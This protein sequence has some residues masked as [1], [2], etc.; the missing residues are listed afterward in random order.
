[1]K[2]VF[3]RIMSLLQSRSI[4]SGVLLI[5][6][7]FLLSGCMM[8]PPSS[9][10][11]SIET[12]LVSLDEETQEI[13]LTPSF[14]PISTTKVGTSVQVD[15]TI[16][17]ASSVTPR[18]IESEK[19]QSISV[20]YDATFSMMGFADVLGVTSY[21]N[22]LSVV[23]SSLGISFPEIAQSQIK[24]Y[25]MNKPS[26]D[27]FDGIV[28]QTSMGNP[29]FYLNGDF[30]EHPERVKLKD[31][32]TVQR[33]LRMNEPVRGFQ[34]G[35][36]A[37]VTKESREPVSEALGLLKPD[38]FLVVVTD[39]EELQNVGNTL[40]SHIQENVYA[41]GM[42][43]SITAINSSF[44]GFVPLISQGV[45]TWF[46]WG[47]QPT[48]SC[49]RM[50]DYQDYKIG[51]TIDPTKRESQK[52]PFYIICA[53]NSDSVNGYC[54]AVLSQLD[55]MKIPSETSIF[56]FNIEPTIYQKPGDEGAMVYSKLEDKTNT[57]PKV[58]SGI[59]I[60]PLDDDKAVKNI[61][62]EKGKSDNGRLIEFEIEIEP[63]DG[64]PRKEVLSNDSKSS[65]DNAFFVNVFLQDLEA[66]G[67]YGE[68][69]PVKQEEI[70]TSCSTENEVGVRDRVNLH[71]RY[72][73]PEKG[74]RLEKGMRYLVTTEV[75]MRAP[76]P[77]Q[78]VLPSWA[79]SYDVDLDNDQYLRFLNGQEEFN[80]NQT[81]GLKGLL[82]ALN[83][84]RKSLA[85]NMK[86]HEYSF[87]LMVAF[88]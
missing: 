37:D 28:E 47:A 15:T 40:I 84:H 50:F 27:L 60:L 26:G 70:I 88:P 68:K 46:E 25:R 16:E 77:N 65:F 85:N 51:L 74:N 14:S 10:T 78:Y 62:L 56:D 7:L 32:Q 38:G 31:S 76:T 49:E 59:N 73:F 13:L 67:R 75:H 3:S 19:P 12:S 64:D 6:V 48:G 86:I 52:R 44:S 33:G 30:L 55:T 53:G 54:R 18:P 35:G 39:L 87:E 72:S 71:I 82:G 61:Q 29:S 11:Q 1:M 45:P 34:E 81:V 69:R 41:K 42:I 36:K 20:C 66:D 2:R 63:R 23:D 43:M 57:F 5:V 22:V 21:K 17:V 83:D 80:G 9:T 8:T 4:I 24:R 79:A 58:S